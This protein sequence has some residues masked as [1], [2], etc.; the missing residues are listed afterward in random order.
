MQ[1]EPLWPST[2][3]YRRRLTPDNHSV[4]S[5]RTDEY[6]CVAWA[7][8]DIEAWWWPGSP[9]S[10]WPA[11]VR[12]DETLDAFHEAFASLG[13]ETCVSAELEDGFEKVALYA[14]AEGPS[15]MARQLAEG[16]WTSKLGALQ[17]IEHATPDDLADDTYGR[18]VL[19]MRRPRGE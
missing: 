8:G 4:T 18:I 12:A 15:H 11:G 9:D 1:Q 16:R 10:F 2:L 6:N 19:L 7:A 14:N 3:V 17:D 5:S 13:Y